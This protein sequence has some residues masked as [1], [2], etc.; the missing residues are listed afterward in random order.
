[1]RDLLE[2]LNLNF[3]CMTSILT[4]LYI[5]NLFDRV[6]EYDNTA[7]SV[8]KMKPSEAKPCNYTEYIPETETAGL[9]SKSG[10]C[11]KILRYNH[12]FIKGYTPK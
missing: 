4:S 2:P 8:I 6:N 7:H 10:D 5:D 11:I 9:N 3:N 12:I 1:M